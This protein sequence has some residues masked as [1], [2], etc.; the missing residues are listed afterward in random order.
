MAWTLSSGFQQAILAGDPENT[1]KLIADTITFTTSA[2]QDSGSGLGV[3]AIGDH[4]RVIGGA[5]NDVVARVITASATELTFAAGTFTAAT[6]GTN[7]A[8][9]ATT[10]G[11][12]MGIL[13]NG[14]LDLYS[15]ALP[16]DADAA[17]TGVKLASI[18]MNGGTF[19][20]D[21]SANGINI[22][23]LSSN[24]MKRAVDP[25]TG[26]TEVWTGDG[27]ADGTAGYGRWYANDVTTGASTSAI[28]MDGTVTT[29]T[30]GDIVMT[31][32]RDIMIGAPATVTDVS[33]TAS[34]V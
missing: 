11:S 27:L 26:T 22:G 24:T 3:F 7:L 28:R 34:G 16:A 20:A 13:R 14:R 1:A 29:S 4:I 15:G 5:N 23:V 25:N 10:G 31:N 32:G 12:F 19:V 21:A 6:A 8:I 2:I 9:E 33:I 30:G 18:T 17:E